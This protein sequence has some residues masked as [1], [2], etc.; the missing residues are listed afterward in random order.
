MNLLNHK[1]NVLGKNIP[2]L[3]LYGGLGFVGY[4]LFKGSQNG[5]STGI[6][7][8]F[9]SESEIQEDKILKDIFK[10]LEKHPGVTSQM[11]VANKA[12]AN[13]LYDCMHGLGTR[14]QGIYEIFRKITGPNMMAAIFLSYG[15]RTL[16]ITTFTTMLSSYSG[17]LVGALRSELSKSE[18]TKNINPDSKGVKWSVDTKLKWLQSFN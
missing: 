16:G 2:S 18:I 7:N 5:V 9:K 8:L 14:T 3:L 4:M 15:K 10:T 13:E 12:M 6:S 11:T 1:S 17:D